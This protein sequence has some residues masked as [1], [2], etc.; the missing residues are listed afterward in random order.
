L[1][2]QLL[3]LI[4][5]DVLIDFIKYFRHLRLSH[6][7]EAQ[8]PAAAPGARSPHGGGD[9][10]TIWR[11]QGKASRIKALTLKP[12]RRDLSRAVAL[13]N[14]DFAVQSLA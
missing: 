12:R 1:V 6:P 8:G 4:A 9:T 2:P 3:E 5:T 10:L 14:I 13:E 11:W 7:H